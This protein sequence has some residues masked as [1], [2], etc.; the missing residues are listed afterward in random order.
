MKK[1]ILALALLW[2][3][4]VNAGAALGHMRHNCMH[5]YPDRLD[6]PTYRREGAR[7]KHDLH[8][9]P[10]RL[11]WPTVLGLPTVSELRQRCYEAQKSSLTTLRRIP[12][13]FF[14]RPSEWREEVYACYRDSPGLVRGIDYVVALTCVRRQRQRLITEHNRNEGWEA[15]D[16]GRYA[17]AIHKWRPL[18]KAGDADSQSALGVMYEHGIG[19]P[20]DYVRAHAWY[21][22]AAEQGSKIAS[23]SK[24]GIAEQNTPTQAA[25][26]QRLRR[27]LCSRIP[28]CA[29]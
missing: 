12:K 18:A 20:K 25:K 4:N 3:V 13:P 8:A 15:Y 23:E 1:L 22:L 17:R 24:D 6:W 19:V 9:N 21:S 29:K 7:R 28:N 11:D 16:R 27:Q 14:L 10:D 2:P 26:A 5:A